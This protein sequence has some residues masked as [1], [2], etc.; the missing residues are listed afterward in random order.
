MVTYN[1]KVQGRHGLLYPPIHAR[2]DEEKRS[3][4][5]L[6]VRGRIK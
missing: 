6:S 3:R 2:G 5:Q 1:Y 4:G